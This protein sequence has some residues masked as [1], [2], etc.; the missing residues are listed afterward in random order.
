MMDRAQQF[1]LKVGEAGRADE[2]ATVHLERRL[3]PLATLGEG[4]RKEFARRLTKNGGVAGVGGGQRRN[5]GIE[6]GPPL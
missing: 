4:Y 2:A 3:D 1:V 6:L 5:A